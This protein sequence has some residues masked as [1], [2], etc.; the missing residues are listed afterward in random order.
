[1]RRDGRDDRSA[2]AVSYAPQTQRAPDVSGLLWI[3]TGYFRGIPLTPYISGM[4]DPL[5]SPPGSARG[6]PCFSLSWPCPLLQDQILLQNTPRIRCCGTRPL[7]ILS[8]QAFNNRYGCFSK[9]AILRRCARKTPAKSFIFE[10][11]RPKLNTGECKSRLGHSRIQLKQSNL[12]CSR[13]WKADCTSGFG[14]DKRGCA[15]LRH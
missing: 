2:S 7:L 4:I 11:H 14:T 8:Q 15:Y 6:Q 10:M 1:M 13:R 3:C 5:P 9:A 12:W